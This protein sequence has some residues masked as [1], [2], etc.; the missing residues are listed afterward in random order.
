MSGSVLTHQR[1][2]VEGHKI[3]FAA[4]IK[5]GKAIVAFSISTPSDVVPLLTLERNTPASRPRVCMSIRYPKP[6]HKSYWSITAASIWPWL[7]WWMPH[8]VAPPARITASGINR[9][10]TVSLTSNM[11]RLFVAVAS[12]HDVQNPIGTYSNGS[13]VDSSRG[14]YF[15]PDIFQHAGPWR[16]WLSAA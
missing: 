11:S 8:S 4:G 13:Y 9:G 5:G 3:T 10:N 1:F 15:G 12:A 16:S 14:V 7:R 6:P 2:I